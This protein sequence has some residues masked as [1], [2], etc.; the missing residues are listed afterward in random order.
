VS[1]PVYYL[2][3][4]VHGIKVASGRAAPRRMSSNTSYNQVFNNRSVHVTQNQP[5]EARIR[6]PTHVS[7]HVE[8]V[9][10]Y[11][12]DQAGNI[13]PARYPNRATGQNNNQQGFT[14][15]AWQETYALPAMRQ[16]VANE[17]PAVKNELATLRKK[18]DHAIGYVSEAEIIKNNQCFIP[19]HRHAKPSAPFSREYNALVSAM[20]R[21]IC[22]QSGQKSFTIAA[23]MALMDSGVSKYINDNSS[24]VQ[25]AL[26][27]VVYELDGGQAP[28]AFPSLVSAAFSEPAYNRKCYGRNCEIEKKLFNSSKYR[29]YSRHYENCVAAVSKNITSTQNNF[30]NQLRAWESEPQRRFEYCQAQLGL[31]NTQEAQ[32]NKLKSREQSLI[33]KLAKLQAKRPRQTASYQNYV[34]AFHSAC[35]IGR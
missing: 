8:D 30:A 7:A 27:F 3:S 22:L 13:I 33:A 14:N 20:P 29:S 23:K 9:C 31:F 18:I 24:S 21:S 25:K 4:N 12:T 17:I 26:E 5:L 11:V 15:R 35:P 16:G 1:R 34:N 28:L 32:L 19:P 6:L 2:N 10:F